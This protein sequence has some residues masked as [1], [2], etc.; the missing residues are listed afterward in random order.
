MMRSIFPVSFVGDLDGDVCYNR[1]VRI[2]HNAGKTSGKN[3]LRNNTGKERAEIVG[4]LAHK[5]DPRSHAQRAKRAR[6]G[7]DKRDD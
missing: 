5:S 6:K 3:A 2:A 4:K 1:S 7:R